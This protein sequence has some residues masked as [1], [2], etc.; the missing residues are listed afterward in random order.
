M[1]D[2]KEEKGGGDLTANLPVETNLD[3]VIGQLR[4]EPAYQQGRSS[5]QLANHDG[6]KVVMMAMAAGAHMKTHTAP[7][8]ISVQTLEGHIRMHTEVRTIDLPAGRL[9]A[10]AAG[11]PHDVQAV[12]ESAFLLTVSVAK[13][14]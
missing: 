3:D 1:N 13:G 7:G 11:L 10:L 5:R 12:Q 9:V 8:A 4:R 14:A 6:L 2:E